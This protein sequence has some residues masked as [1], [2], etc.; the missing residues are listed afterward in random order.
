M[1][2]DP[3][4]DAKEILKEI[5]DIKGRVKYIVCTHQHPDHNLKVKKME[6]ET[7]GRILKD[8]QEGEEIKIGE[9]KI[10]VLKMGGHTKE[11]IC[12]LGDG[13][14]VSGD[15]LF[16]DG[17]GRVDLPGGSREEMKK[18]LG[19]IFHELPKETVVYPGHGEPFLLSEWRGGY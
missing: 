1:V 16:I 7:G 3:G 15:I 9:E 17:H 11:D 12:F 4:G 14:V 10:S 8:L 13:F 2:V 6:K 19:R 5:E 18:T